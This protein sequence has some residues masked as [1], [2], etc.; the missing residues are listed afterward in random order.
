MGILR[1]RCE[2]KSSC[3]FILPSHVYALLQLA[4]LAV[5]MQPFSVGCG[6][7]VHMPGRYKLS[8]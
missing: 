8:L 2:N 6:C 1:D 3:F 4:D 7:N 5:G